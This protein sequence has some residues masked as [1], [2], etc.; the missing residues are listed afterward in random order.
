MRLKITLTLLIILLGLLTYI[1]YIDP[2]SDQS[3]LEG[4]DA[5]ALASLAVDI[6]YL[7]I[8]DDGKNRAL[9][10]E[11]QENDWVL[12]E[13][14][15]WPANTFAVERILTQLQFLDTKVTFGTDRIGQAGSNLAEYGL[16][17]PGLTLEFGSGGSRY[18]IGIGK[19]TDLGNHLYLLS[20]DRTKIHV[21]D[22]SL[23]D[24]LSID[25]ESLRNPRIFRSSIFEVDSWNLQLR[26]NLRT[27]LTKNNS[28]WAIETPIN[29]RADSIEVNTLL[30]KL[31]EMK[32]LRVLQPTPASSDLALYGLQDP[33]L[34]IAIESDQSREALEVG[35]PIDPTETNIR[36]AKLENRNTVFE[37]EIDYL[38]EL[39]TAQTNLRD[40]RIFAIDTIYATSVSFEQGGSESFSLQKLET[41]EWETLIP[42][43]EQGFIRE[44]GS[45]EAVNDALDWLNKVKAV[46][47]SNSS[48]F[49]R[50]APTAAD[51]ESYGLEVPE[52]S[53]RIA[54]ERLKDRTENLKPPRVE[55][56]LFGDRNRAD[57]S[58]RYVKLAESD[59][60]YLVSNDILE[61]VP[62]DSFQ[63]QSRQLFDIPED[64]TINKLSITRLANEETLLDTSIEDSNLPLELVDSLTPL[65]VKSYLFDQYTST[66]SLAGKRQS[67][68]YLMEATFQWASADTGHSESV[69]LFVSELTGGPLLVGGSIDRD[70]VFEF[71][72]PFIDA[73][74]AVVFDRVKRPVPEEPF[75]PDQPL[76][77]AEEDP[78]SPDTEQQ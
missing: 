50:D 24:S 39:E 8:Y 68:A 19:A 36:Y 7:R 45:N 52:Y 26:E 66:V 75:D 21:V 1:F 18:S 29:T 59:F 35:N 9:T 64:A 72:Q 61:M 57:R 16:A 30:G 3:Q 12:T 38:T 23:L 14:F 31:L 78:A 2:W 15:S 48:G 34:R 5:N 76:P 27:R 22:R 49:V 4:E 70:S 62:D 37:I 51:L 77:S 6:D 41:D 65:Q 40:R 46:A 10:L 17:P 54:S 53:I 73:F 25:I 32:S 43:E 71:R 58:L 33:F 28:H 63:Y 11:K 55:T 44:K 67:W 20:F 56:L 42:D 47:T 60:V 74:S 13:P 69:E